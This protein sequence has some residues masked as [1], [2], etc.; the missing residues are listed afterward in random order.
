MTRRGAPARARAPRDPYGI[1]PVSGYIGPAVGVIALVLIGAVTLSLFN[2][3]IPFVKTGLAGDGGGNGTDN[4]P[5][6]TAAPSGVIITVPKAVFPGS[7]VYAKAGNIWIQTDKG[8][9]QQLTSSGNDSMPT[10]SADGKFI[11]FIRVE[12]GTGKFPTGG[13]LSQ[14][15]SWYDLSTPALF[16]M[17]PDG[18]G[19]QRL[20]NGRFIQQGGSTWFYWLRQPV[21][22]P[23]G[24]TV[25]V[26]S[27]G[28]NPLQSDIVL[29][30]FS[31]ASKKLTSLNLP[32]SLHLGQQ[33]PAWSPDGKFL[34]YVQNGRELTRGAP[35]LYRYE[36][37]TKK[38]RALTGPGYVSP[39]YS[40]DGTWIAATNTDAFGTDI[41]ILDQAGKEVLRVTSDSH[42]FSPVWS[43]AGDAIAFLHLDGTIVDLRMAKL[44]R[45]SGRWVVTDTVDLT[46]VSAL[47]GESRPSWFIPAAELPAP[48]TAPSAAGSAGSSTAP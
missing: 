39:A 15:K 23:D 36:V 6:A 8:G 47:D 27:D 40:P 46:K 12:E 9:A 37:A 24:K 29:H 28:P 38:A 48:S 3:Q 45:G 25:V 14:G 21:P 11:Y 42:S 4:G 34:L 19:A 17:N 32:E 7:I 44:D 35:Q 13:I 43:P 30:S 10:F 5:A 31:L 26:V 33:D 16:R 18:S 20:L 41:A 22:S 1:G 2:G